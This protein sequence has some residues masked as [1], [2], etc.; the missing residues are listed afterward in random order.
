[1]L[2]YSWRCVVQS[3]VNRGGYVGPSQTLEVVAD[4]A[5][6]SQRV[7]KHPLAEEN[8]DCP[9]ELRVSYF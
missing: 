6:A 4:G 9:A 8:G 2:Q 3:A 7:A 5:T 1:M